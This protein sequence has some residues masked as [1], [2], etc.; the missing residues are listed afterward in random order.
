MP[1]RTVTFDRAER[2]LTLRFQL[3]YQLPPYCGVIRS[4]RRRSAEC[5]KC[6]QKVRPR[7]DADQPP[8]AKHRKP[9]DNVLFHLIDYIDQVGIFRHGLRVPCHQLVDEAAVSM[10]IFS[11]RT[12]GVSQDFT[13][14][15]GRR[16]VSQFDAA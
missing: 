12:A 11:R 1:L 14:S 5:S 6:A 3:L 15:E 13:P 16:L 10:N 8:V 4:Y 9:F 2:G 7:Y